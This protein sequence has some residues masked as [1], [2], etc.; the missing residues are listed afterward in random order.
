MAL[1]LCP[2]PT[3]GTTGASVTEARLFI[4]IARGRHV[5][6]DVKS[7]VALL[8]SLVHRMLPDPPSPSTIAQQRRYPIQSRMCIT[9]VRKSP[10]RLFPCLVQVDPS[11]VA[12][13]IGQR[14][15]PPAAVQHSNLSP[16]R[17]EVASTTP[18]LGIYAGFRETRRSLPDVVPHFQ[19]D[20]SRTDYSP[21][22]P[23]FSPCSSALVVN[24]ITPCRS[25][26]PK[27]LLTPSSRAKLD[28]RCPGR[29][30]RCRRSR[31]NVECLYCI[32]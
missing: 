11:V 14:C 3:T 30:G 25:L 5:C 8:L 15:N 19:Q 23:S 6:P 27:M 4:I 16:A 28:W 18:R 26:C 10:F 9:A 1:Y 2:V 12:L 7:S 29:F 32:F 17:C 13:V 20:V 22:S 31:C 21:I 24:R